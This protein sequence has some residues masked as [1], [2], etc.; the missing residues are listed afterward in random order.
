MQVRQAKH[1]QDKTQK[2]PEVVEQNTQDTSFS[3]SFADK[4]PPL[5]SKDV[6]IILLF[7]IKS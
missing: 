3:I 2:L 1:L 7:E 4:E 5:E 6:A